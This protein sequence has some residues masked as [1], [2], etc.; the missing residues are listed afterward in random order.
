MKGENCEV[1][2][3]LVEGVFLLGSEGCGL[4]RK[5]R[6]IV[7]N[8]L[9]WKLLMILVEVFGSSFSEVVGVKV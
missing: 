4:R 6:L 8:G 7:L 9:V 3:R 5:E 1:G 2:G